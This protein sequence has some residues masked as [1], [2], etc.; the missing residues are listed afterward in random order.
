MTSK[1]EKISKAYNFFYQSEIEKIHFELSDIAYVTGW[2][3]STIDAYKSKKW[4]E[5]LHVDSDG[6]YCQGISSI[7]YKEFV[8]FHRQSVKHTE[9]KKSESDLFLE[10][11]REFALLAVQTYNNPI[12][13]FRFYG[14]I[15]YMIISFT[16]LFHS[17]FSRERIK[18]WHEKNGKPILID[19]DL[20]YWELD[21]CLN[22]YYKGQNNAI[23]SNLKLFLG[24]RNKI[25]HRNLPN[26]DIIISGYSQA[27]FQNYEQLLIKEFG[28]S[29]SLS[30]NLALAIQ[31]SSFSEEYWQTIRSI[32]SS[33]YNS[34]KEYIDLFCGNLPIDIVKSDNFCFRVFVI[35]KSGN[36]ATSSDK[37]IEFVK[38][39]PNNPSDVELSE[40][41]IG[42]IK[43][44]VVQVADQGKLRATSVAKEVEA[45]TQKTF[46]RNMHTKAWKLYQVRNKGYSAEGCNTKFCSFSEP[47][48]SYLYTS[49]WVDFLCEKVLDEE[50]YKKIVLFK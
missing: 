19:N 24:L 39:D 5:F 26:L 14:F 21:T 28:I 33:N 17:I 22:E 15:I 29:Q 42:L 40:R 49:A 44:K 2:A 38:F 30:P 48:K 25:E 31:L 4:S 35:P 34:I 11:S 3:M 6:Y 12:N 47:F 32:S 23:V 41:V 13:N 43:E 16:A 9:D 36:H 50:E 7:P 20:K 8:D 46:T 18:F 45:R 27:L 1:F 37:S 10:K